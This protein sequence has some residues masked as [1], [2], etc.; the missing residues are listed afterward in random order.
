MISWK[1]AGM[2]RR[3]SGSIDPHRCKDGSVSYRAR[4]TAYGRAEKVTLGNSK[5]GWNEVRAELELEKIVQQIERG[6][7]V[8]SRMRPKADRLADAMAALGV[9]V[10]EQFRTFANTWW[11]AKRLTLDA[12]TVVD[13]AWRLSYLHPFFDRYRL[14]E[15][16]VRVVDRF[17][18]ELADQ[19]ETIRQ[20]ERRGKPLMEQV[21]DMRGRT[22][23]RRHRP[24]S[25]RSINMLLT[26]LGQ[27]LQQACDYELIASN[28]VRVKGRFLK[29]PKQK[30][31]FLEID[32]FHS[33]L[34]AAAELEAEARSNIQG[35]GRRAMIATLG[36]AGQRV[37]EMVDLRVAN[38][39][40]HRARFKLPD[41]KTPAGV[42]EVE[43][44]MFLLDE[45]LAYVADRRSRGL[46]HGPQDYFFGTTSGKR[47]DP[48]RFRDRI[49]ARSLERASDNRSKAGLMPMPDDIT[50]HALRR[51]WAN[52][53]A[54]AGRT[55]KW[56]A[57]QIG[58]EDPDL[59]FR[60]YQQ[61]GR[62]RYV[63]EQAIW[64]VMHF[65]DEPEERPGRRGPAPRAVTNPAHQSAQGL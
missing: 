46:P 24:L 9:E 34:D 57:D 65:A 14:G 41:A 45:L 52:F 44:T 5:H 1:N 6:T 47:R 36:L 8:P 56:I 19:A 61:M 48:D 4:V 60:A 7:W 38:V 22:Y 28:P 58:H 26:L 30:K 15:I 54:V 53:A 33:L 62:R 27:I 49:L 10:D 11:E 43:I 64:S 17:R 32:E 35:L 31:S 59:A 40:L 29:Q 25:N 63:D 2:A 37:S 55:P 16:T 39:D 12:K 50:P 21:T 23:K 42:R 18:D 20:A 3:L 51:T 13:Y